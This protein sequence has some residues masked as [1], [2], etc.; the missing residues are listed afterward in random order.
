MPAAYLRGERGLAQPRARH[1]AAPAD[2]L[3]ELVEQLDAND[4]P[5]PGI[6]PVAETLTG[7]V[8]ASGGSNIRSL[9]RRSNAL[10]LRPEGSRP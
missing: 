4:L 9:L 10:L 5:D 2:L 8:P 3:A 6:A 1:A 7:A